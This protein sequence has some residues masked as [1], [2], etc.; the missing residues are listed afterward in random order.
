MRCAAGEQL[1]AFLERGLSIRSERS[2]KQRDQLLGREELRP[3]GSSPSSD[4]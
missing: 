2:G 1:A 4:F 3:A